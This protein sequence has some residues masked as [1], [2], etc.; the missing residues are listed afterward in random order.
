MP[1]LYFHDAAHKTIYA[2]PAEPN[3]AMDPKGGHLITVDW[4]ITRAGNY[5]NPK[6]H[7]WAFPRFQPQSEHYLPRDSR[8]TAIGYFK[9]S[10]YPHYPQVNQEEAKRIQSIYEAQAKAHRP[11]NA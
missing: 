9:S 7:Q 3:V 4:E 8:E 10:K 6:T 11:G 5:I 2:V 1:T